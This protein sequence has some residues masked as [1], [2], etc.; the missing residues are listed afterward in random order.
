MSLQE[1]Q[2]KGRLPVIL[3]GN[4]SVMAWLVDD[5][6]YVTSANGTAFQYPLVDA[7]LFKAEGGKAAV[8]CGLDGCE[9]ELETGAVIRWCPQEDSPLS[10]RNLFGGLKRASPPVALPVYPTRVSEA[11]N[12]EV[13]LSVDA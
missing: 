11:G 5:R 1:L 8:R 3:A 12:V 2:A 4:R 13:F 9:Y 6:V 7:E 10:L